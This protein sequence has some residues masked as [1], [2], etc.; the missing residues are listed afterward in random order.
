[1]RRLQNLV[2]VLWA[3]ALLLFVAFNWELSLRLV[4]VRYLFVQVEVH[5]LLWLLLGAFAVPL[6]LRILGAT[7][8]TTTR[9]RS[10]KELHVVK[11]RAYDGL[12]GEFSRLGEQLQ[13][14]LEGY[15]KNLAKPDGP[16]GEAPAGNG[17]D[18]EPPP[19]TEKPKGGKAK[20]A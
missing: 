1:M 3:V 19:P 12:S 2:L 5:L 16:A 4:E 17:A 15:V 14:R 9:R 6:L 7:E 8:T 10:E 18:Q 11:A 13:E 20:G